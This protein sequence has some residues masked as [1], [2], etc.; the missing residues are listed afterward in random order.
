MKRPEELYKLRLII[1]TSLMILCLC[2]TSAQA[3]Y[4][5]GTGQPNNPYQIA[6][7]D[8]LMLLGDSPEDYD[9]HFM[10]TANIDLAPSLPGRKVFDRAVIAPDTDPIPNKAGYNAYDGTA[11][12]GVFNGDGFAIGN[13]HIQGSDHLG[14]F[15]QLGYGAVVLDLVLQEVV[16][17]GTGHDIGGLVGLSAG[18]INVCSVNKGSVSGRFYAGGIA[19]ET[20][21]AISLSHSNVE[22]SGELSIGG[23]VGR[24]FGSILS[25]YSTGTVTG[26]RLYVGGLVGDNNNGGSI[27]NSYSSSKVNGYENVGGLVGP[28]FGSIANSYSVGEVSGSRRVGGLVAGGW[29]AG[30]FNC[31]WDIQTSTV[32]NSN[33][34]TGLT[35]EEMRD[36]ETYLSA[37]WDFIDEITNGTCDYWQA[38]PGNYPRLSYHTSQSPVMPEGLG[39]AEQPYMIRDAR[40][41]GTIW[42]EPSAHYRLE[43]SLDL[44]GITWSTA[45]VPCFGGTFDGNGYVISNLRIHGSGCLG[46]FGQLSSGANIA[47]LDL[48]AVDVN[49]VDGQIGSFAAEN[50]GSITS[51]YSTGQVSGSKETGGIVGVNWGSITDSISSC[52]TT[53]NGDVGGLVGYNA[54]GSISS[55]YNTGAVNGINNVGGLVGE[56][57]WGNISASYNAGLVNGFENIGGAVGYSRCGRI[58]N[59]YNTGTIVGSDAV[60][61]LVGYNEIRCRPEG[62]NPD[63]DPEVGWISIASSYS[64]GAVNGIYNVGG[65]VGIASDPFYESG[66]D[67]SNCFWDMNTSGQITSAGGTCR[68]TAEMQMA[69]T[70]LD[71]GWDFVDETANGTDNVWWILEGQDYPRLWWELI[72]ENR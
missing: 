60:G 24:N 51:G 57:L 18:S 46:L 53:G 21:G 65:L 5:G 27:A 20:G 45:I 34:G 70:F 48:E 71:A 30:V 55:C 52:T 19:G 17:N 41:L 32:R 59:S 35:T 6:T 10:L 39:T 2:S 56:D 47:N 67:V 61:G 28:N 62:E 22:I 37:G 43:E 64:I 31:F 50:G 49:G 38:S 8:D 66:E 40:N 72:A 42:L 1:I 29:Q 25:S 11:F 54:R 7:A 44:M 63:I 12:T 13:L 33:G 9:K 3:K 68:T 4:S 69:N 58:S 36:I 26:E 15:G 23:L 16:V 14:L